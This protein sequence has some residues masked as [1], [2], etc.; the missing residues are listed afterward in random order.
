[1]VINYDEYGNLQRHWIRWRCRERWR[2]RHWIERAGRRGRAWT[3]EKFAAETATPS[4][5]SSAARSNSHDSAQPWTQFS[6]RRPRRFVS[7]LA[8]PP[9]FSGMNATRSLRGIRYECVVVTAEVAE[10]FIVTISQKLHSGFCV[11]S[12]IIYSI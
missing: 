4:P 8:S 12:I 6:W 9:P 7:A 10:T 5:R 2:W 11:T 3:W 1:M